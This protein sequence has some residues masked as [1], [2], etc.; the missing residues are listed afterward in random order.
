VSKTALPAA[1]SA[2]KLAAAGIERRTK[3]IAKRFIEYP[4]LITSRRNL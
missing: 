4:F 3:L 1:A 2:A